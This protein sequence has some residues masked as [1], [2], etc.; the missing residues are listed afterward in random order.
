MYQ[1]QSR[2][3]FENNNG[4]LAAHRARSVRT[5]EC[6][7]VL[8]PSLVAVLVSAVVA[9]MAVCPGEGLAQPAANDPF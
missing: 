7:P 6:G 1:G 2:E 9:V 5:Q 8:R 4:K 3:R